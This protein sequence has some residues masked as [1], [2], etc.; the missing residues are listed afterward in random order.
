MAT[1]TITTTSEQD[2]RISEAFGHYLMLEGNASG[3][4]VRAFIIEKIKEV[5]LQYERNQATA[6]VTPIDVQ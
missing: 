4:Q 5:V 1:I 6:S 3:A 2:A